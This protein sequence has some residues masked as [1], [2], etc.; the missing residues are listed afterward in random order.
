MEGG[1]RVGGE[2]GGSCCLRKK[3]GKL[4]VALESRWV[5][6]WGNVKRDEEKTH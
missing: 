4:E 5:V 1:R 3:K 2:G 6:C